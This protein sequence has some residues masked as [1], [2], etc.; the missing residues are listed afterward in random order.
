MLNTKVIVRCDRSGVFFGTLKS[1][2]GQTAELENFRK[3]W[4]FS[5]AKSVEQISIDGLNESS[6]ITQ[7]V[8]LGVV[9]DAIQILPCTEESI[10]SIESKPEW[11]Q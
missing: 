1:I 8:K 3:I 7:V 5:G 6:K 4:Y 10:I 11:K 2:S 9:T